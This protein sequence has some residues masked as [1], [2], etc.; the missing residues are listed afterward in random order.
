MPAHRRH[1]S[2][3][4][5]TNAAHAAFYF[6]RRTSIMRQ[7]LSLS[8]LC[9]ALPAISQ[10]A[11]LGTM[12]PA[13]PVSEARIAASPPA[14][15]AAWT[16]YLARSR[17]LMA[18][19]KAALLAEKASPDAGAGRPHSTAPENG[20]PLRKAAAWYATPE[21]LRVADNIL[22]FQ[23]PAGGWGKNADRGGLPR[24]PG[25]SWA[26][27]ESGEGKTSWNYVGTIDNGATTGEMRF[28]ARVQNQLGDK[29]EP[30]RA[31]FLK[32]LRYLLNAQ[33]PNGGFPQVYPL[34]GGYHDAVTLNDDAMARVVALLMD[35]GEGRSDFAFVP[36][37]LV[38]ETRA[39]VHRSVGLLLATQQLNGG[40]RTGWGQQYDALTL[41]L[42]GARNFEPASLSSAES[43][44]VL[45]LLMRLP[46]PTPAV[47]EA[48]NGG[49]AWLRAAALRDVAWKTDGAQGRRLLPAPGA[50]E[51]WSRYYDARSL[52][53]I[54]GDRDRSI[55]DDIDEIGAERRNG[56]AWF[57]SN[58]GRA[59]ERHAAW[60]NPSKPARVILVGDSTMA[61]NGGY[62]DALCRRLQPRVV[63]VNKGR[64]GRS[65]SS[66]RLEGWWDEIGGL[67]DDNRNYSRNYVLIQFGHNDQPGKPGRSTDLKTEFP[68]NMGRY[69]QEVTASGAEPV[70]VTPLSRRNFE[71]GKLADT[72]APWA[73]ATRA[74]AAE[75]R[76]KVIELHAATMAAFA[77]LGE[78]E[79]VTL[80]PAPKSDAK[81]PDLT[82]LNA[83]GAEIVA[84]IMLKELTGAIPSLSTP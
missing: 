8:A 79:A 62:G 80:G 59:I 51:I 27:P 53:P 28:L 43:A 75:R 74:V 4:V 65:T 39:A 67:L 29:G 63:C 45:M 22:S 19:D 3:K 6:L 1:G 66:Y 26:P 23:T 48:V 57:G 40:K 2:G 42:A 77:A 61:P 13:E 60:S 71:N 9:L 21:A 58:P 30:Y 56:Y 34:Q 64:A 69:A 36:A 16:A 11:V 33:Y 81:G 5:V 47:R 12:T 49:V 46:E 14:Q 73:A 32:G 44:G 17:A 31:A 25:E 41:E 35:I 76:L 7:A 68:A 84:P 83:K 54:F 55:H 15:R 72:L 50:P 24:R 20:M 10:A 82:H 18:A 70:L 38:E 52:K 78:A 37:A